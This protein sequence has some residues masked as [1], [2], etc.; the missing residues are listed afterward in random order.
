M[1][2]K[3]FSLPAI[4]F[5]MLNKWFLYSA[6]DLYIQQE[7]YIFSNL[8][9]AFSNMRFMF[10]NL[11]LI[12]M[13]QNIHPKAFG[14]TKYLVCKLYI[15]SVNIFSHFSNVLCTLQGWCWRAQFSVSFYCPISQWIYAK[16]WGGCGDM[17]K[18]MWT[19][20]FFLVS[21]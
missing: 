15:Q 12:W 8:K 9:F 7:I 20:T 21:A 18:C 11:F 13:E 6:N 4:D 1:F 3:C 17:I 16:N 14:R 19:S 10:N 2:N 5:Y